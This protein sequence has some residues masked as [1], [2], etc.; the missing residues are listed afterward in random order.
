[1]LS[2]LIHTLPARAQKQFIKS[3]IGSLNSSI[4]GNIRGHIR[5]D[6][7]EQIAFKE[8]I[9][10][11]DDFNDA[12]AAIG[13]EQMRDAAFSDAGLTSLMPSIEIAAHLNIIR[14]SLVEQLSQTKS[15]EF[16]VPLS[17][18]DTL[19]F[20]LERAPS[21]NEARLK[22]L[23]KALDKDYELLKHV[24][25]DAFRVEREQLAKVAGQVLTLIG[26]LEDQGDADASFDA[27]PAHVRFKLVASSI[28]ALN[29]AGEQALMQLLRFNKMDGAT[30]HTLIEA[31]IKECKTWLA[32]FQREHSNEL[33]EYI[34]RGGVLPEVNMPPALAPDA[35]LAA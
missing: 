2:T 25:I 14:A 3:M 33:N 16:D 10:T 11:I 23:A 29:K 20:Q 26:M 4:I 32:Q 18:P 13:E 27:L 31:V 17:I 8:D 28:K 35:I 24:Q 34:E 30:D 9:P 6:A 22:M 5:Q 15:T 19:K 1:M 12:M 21:I 7:L